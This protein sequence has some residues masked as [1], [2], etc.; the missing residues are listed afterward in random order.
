V[1]NK[2][3][4]SL[5]LSTNQVE[6]GTVRLKRYAEALKTCE[7]HFYF[8]PMAKDAPYLS[9]LDNEVLPDFGNKKEFL[10]IKTPVVSVEY[11]VDVVIN[12]N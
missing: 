6:Y 12:K 2:I 5:S 8:M 9:Y 1:S 10:E 7:M 11:K 3:A 4:A